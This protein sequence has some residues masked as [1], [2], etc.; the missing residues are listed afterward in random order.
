MPG[1]SG[2]LLLVGAG[3]VA[4]GHGVLAAGR[5]AGPAGAA[6]VGGQLLRRHQAAL[7]RGI[8]YVR[9]KE[10]K[11]NNQR[12]DLKVKSKVNCKTRIKSAVIQIRPKT[13]R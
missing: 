11:Q 5:A 6:G 10:S 13:C 1:R 2:E 9:K 4:R 12:R 7:P 8:K 3:S